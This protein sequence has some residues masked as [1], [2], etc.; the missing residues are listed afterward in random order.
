[1]FPRLWII[2]ME[3][4]GFSRDWAAGATGQD[5]HVL[6]LDENGLPL[7]Y[8]YMQSCE[9]ISGYGA[10][11]SLPIQSHDTPAL[12]QSNNHSLPKTD[13]HQYEGRQPQEA[14]LPLS[15]GYFPEIDAGSLGYPFS[16]INP[17]QLSLFHSS[18]QQ[19]ST[20][21]SMTS[22]SSFNDMPDL[23]SS[24]STS[25]SSHNYS[26]AIPSHKYLHPSKHQPRKVPSSRSSSS[27]SNSPIKQRKSNAAKTGSGKVP[28]RKAMAQFE[29]ALK[30]SYPKLSKG[31]Q[32]HSEI[33]LAQFKLLMEKE[34]AD[35]NLDAEFDEMS[36][37]TSNTQDTSMSSDIMDSIFPTGDGSSVTSTP[38]PYRH[39]NDDPTLIGAEPE[40]RVKYY[41]TFPNCSVTRKD[42]KCRTKNC[43]CPR[44]RERYWSH[45][46]V[47]LRRHEEGE[48]HWP[49]ENF[50]CLECP[51]IV[52]NLDGDPMCSFCFVPF[53]IL[54]EP[55]AH[56]LQCE[57]AR[58][59]G[60]TFGRKD[61]LCGH[62][63][64]H[65]GME[66]MGE[67]TKSWSFP[68]DS[69]WPR[70]CGFCGI[71]FST[72]DQRMKHIGSHFDKG[73][74]IQNW[75]LP[76]LG[77]KDTKP[78][79]PFTSYR[80]E[81]DDDDDD[82]NFGGNGGNSGGKPFSHGMSAVAPQS[83][84]QGQSYSSQECG[85]FHQG[86][87][88]QGYSMGS[89]SSI[90]HRSDPL[91]EPITVFSP[92][93]GR[94]NEV[95]AHLDTGST[96]NWIS[97]S[98]V[99]RLGLLPVVSY[100]TA[101]GKFFASP[102]VL[103]DMTWST[104]GKTNTCVADF[105]VLPRKHDAPFDVLL[106]AAITYQRIR[107][108]P[109]LT[110]YSSTQQEG[111]RKTTPPRTLGRS[112][113]PSL[114][115]ERYLID[116]GD[117]V[118]ALS[119]SPQPT[120]RESK[121][122]KTHFSTFDAEFPKHVNQ[123]SQPHV[124][125]RRLSGGGKTE[126]NEMTNTHGHGSPQG[127]D[128]DEQCAK[129]LR[130]QFESLLRMKRLNE[131][132]RLR[133][134]YQVNSPQSPRHRTSIS[135]NSAGFRATPS[136]ASLRNL[137]RTPS[138][139]AD[140]ASQ[141]FQKLQNFLISLSSTS[142]KHWKDSRGEIFWVKS[143]ADSNVKNSI[144]DI[145]AQIILQHP[146][147]TRMRPEFYQRWWQNHQNICPG[148]SPHPCQFPDSISNFRSVVDICSALQ[149]FHSK[150]SQIKVTD[151]YLHTMN[152][153]PINIVVSSGMDIQGSFGSLL[154]PEVPDISTKGEDTQWI[155]ARG[156]RPSK[157]GG[158]MP[159][160]CGEPIC[161]EESI[162]SYDLTKHEKI[163]S[164]PWKCSFETCKYY[165]VGWPTEKEMDR[166]HSDKHADQYQLSKL[167][168]LAYNQRLDKYGRA[169]SAMQQEEQKIVVGIDFGT[170][171]SG[172]AWA[173]TNLV[174]HPVVETFIV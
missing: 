173:N 1:V 138:L 46:K 33:L 95:T 71:F 11:Q 37:A 67:R 103:R 109:T 133:S 140:P 113:K 139:P 81:E 166:H 56:Y 127:G 154:A 145:A 121:Q 38:R 41:C 12:Y 170:T 102:T 78:P 7:P 172:V 86:Y 110:G 165:E 92:K 126:D 142:T 152:Y 153:R 91:R 174:R 28:P 13:L 94:W 159:Q 105:R 50:T 99:K 22:S 171:Y 111:N 90:R 164:R 61:H 45:S 124:V 96:D 51:S 98:M 157:D 25:G 15:P 162:R 76:F 64:E 161:D 155:I 97:E 30:S 158:A 59:N 120:A 75:K 119:A 52:E 118:P 5:G 73:S 44:K 168:A 63:R 19:P 62:L 16:S 20:T 143:K 35:G 47:D 134:T 122:T 8:Q 112:F 74:K 23:T 146:Q 136:Y 147:A 141:K 150:L 42:C 43:K 70:Q 40:C 169:I 156:K 18:W 132:G 6:V 104:V 82:D 148:L 2:T 101:A 60:K 32:Q 39:D 130:L 108:D 26:N 72:W 116:P 135:S 65:H 167:D 79:G 53:S 48:K 137:P 29:S 66:D 106:G 69:D 49:Q 31:F 160:R 151:Y 17:Q 55:K 57:M 36:L 100:R 85:L 115:L 88:H 107:E 34:I 89:S 4:N 77:P 27:F 58:Q 125:L 93:L 144:L 68:I 117:R 128:Y 123:I 21:S 131:L 80:R 83:T 9:N 84:H 10:K 3:G 114:A 129:D 87:H 163:H 24:S 149:F 14:S 54:G